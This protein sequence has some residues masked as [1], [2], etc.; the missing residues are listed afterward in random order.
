MKLF[1]KGHRS[2]RII[3]LDLLRI[4]LAILTFLFH[5]Y[6]HFQCRYGIMNNFISVGAIAM[7]AFF[8]LSGYSLQISNSQA[9]IWSIEELKRFYIK[10]LISILPLYLFIHLVR[11]FICNSEPIINRI[12]MFP[13]QSLCIQSCFSSLFNHVHNGGSWF[14]SC[15][16]IC[17][18]IFPLVHIIFSRLS[19]KRTI[20]LLLLLVFV[21]LWS[22]LVQMKMNTN[23]LYD[24]PFFRFVEFSI[25]ML[26]Y[27][28]NRQNIDNHFFKK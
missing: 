3:G 18:F 19:K 6:I 15:L 26:L 8:M 11:M 12:L 9:D 13:I 27:K 4:S 10:R 16:L 25:G 17:Y 21:V 1:E 22:P 2:K 23:S 7:T 28:I 24:N 14:I 20:Y 5:S